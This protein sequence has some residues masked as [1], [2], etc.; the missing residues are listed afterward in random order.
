M[1]KQTKLIIGLALSVISLCLSIL[2]LTDAIPMSPKQPK[3][4]FYFI[5]DGL[6]FNHTISFLK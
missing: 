5:G 2:I 4:I 1:K 6:N 3:Y